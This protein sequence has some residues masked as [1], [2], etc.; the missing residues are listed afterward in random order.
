MYEVHHGLAAFGP[1][2]LK[3]RERLEGKIL[4][5]AEEIAAEPR[6]YP[7]LLRVDDLAMLDYFQ[8]FPHLA[9]VASRIQPEVLKEQYADGTTVDSVPP[10]HLSPAQYVLPSAACYNIYLHL[11]GQ[12]LQGPRYI[13]TVATCFRNENHYQELQRLWSFSMREVVC[14]GSAEE[15]QAHLGGFKE[16]ILGLSEQLGLNLDIQVATDPFYEP[17][18]SRAIMQKVFPQKEEFV[19]SGSDGAVAIASLNFHRNFFGE[20][21]QIQL[22]DGSPAFTGCAAFGIER[23]YYALLDRFHQDAD[24]VLEALG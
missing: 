9:V 19:F 8:N 13:T 21:C 14:I 24:A 22:A 20:R 7:P 16:R 23:W 17:Q 11:K 12:V 6:L 5:W 2:I 3:I 15:V 1:Q 18:S 4:G 10:E